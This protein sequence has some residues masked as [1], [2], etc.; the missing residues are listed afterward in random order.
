MGKTW[1][2]NVAGN[3]WKSAVWGQSDILGRTVWK[4]V[5]NLPGHRIPLRG[6]FENADS[7]STSLA[8]AWEPAFLMGFRAALLLLVWDHTVRN[9]TQLTKPASSN[10]RQEH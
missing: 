7:H 5:S 10:N 8:G 3:T 9:R 4:W 2:Q 1:K 6:V